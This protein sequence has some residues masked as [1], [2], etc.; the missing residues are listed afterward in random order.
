[1]R[2][3]KQITSHEIYMYSIFQ[4]YI[5]KYI[6][7]DENAEKRV[8]DYK[9]RTLFDYYM[10]WCKV[11]RVNTIF[12]ALISWFDIQDG[13]LVICLKGKYGEYGELQYE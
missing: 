1:M 12:T 5:V 3:L 11:G 4:N 10:D 2:E 6:Q 9:Y 7:Y 13:I 8:V